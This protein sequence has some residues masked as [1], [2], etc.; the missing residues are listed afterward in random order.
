MLGDPRFETKEACTSACVFLSHPPFP[1]DCSHAT[2]DC[3]Y[4]TESQQYTCPHAAIT[5]IL[6]Y[7]GWERPDKGQ[8]SDVGRQM[9]PHAYEPLTLSLAGSLP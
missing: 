2:S 8:D 7:R 9:A 5:I 6:V 3:H 1:R 4:L